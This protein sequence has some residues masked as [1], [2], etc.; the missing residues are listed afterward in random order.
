[1]APTLMQQPRVRG[2]VDCVY[3]LLETSAH[4]VK[5]QTSDYGPMLADII[6]LIAKM[7]ATEAPHISMSVFDQTQ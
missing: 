1:M 3:L 2:I 6:E 7:L 4:M 5:Y